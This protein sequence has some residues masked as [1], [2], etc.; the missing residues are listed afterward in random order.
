MKKTKNIIALIIAGITYGSFGV[1]IRFLSQELTTYQQ[2]FVRNFLGL[3]FAFIFVLLFKENINLKKVNKKHLA[4]YAISFPITQV[5]YTFSILKIKIGVALFSFFAASFI[6]SFIVGRIYFSDKIN[7]RKVISLILAFLGITI[8]SYKSLFSGFLNWG[9]ILGLLSGCFDTITNTG[10]RLLGGKVDRFVLVTTQ[11]IGGVVVAILLMFVF[12]QHMPTSVSPLTALIAILFG[13]LLMGLNILMNFG[14]K[15][16]DLNLGTILL[17][18][19]L[20][21]AP[22]LGYLFFRETLSGTD[23]AGGIFIFTGIIV[24]NLPGIRYGKNK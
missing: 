6:T 20:V 17:S 14:F 13:L 2:I 1:W 5:F 9:F 10:R 18:I 24:A 7:L 19:E 3:V 8:L 11:M 4:L 16:F 15:D 21:A 23:I 22:I 12:K